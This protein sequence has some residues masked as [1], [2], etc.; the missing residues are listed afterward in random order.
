MNVNVLKSFIR[1]T[2][3]NVKNVMKLLLDVQI[4]TRRKDPLIVNI[5]DK[6]NAKNV[7]I[8]LK[9]VPNVINRQNKLKAIKEKQFYV[10]INANNATKAGN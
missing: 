5:N 1:L 4:A 3:Q 8:L 7:S 9:I 10:I 2:I 6:I